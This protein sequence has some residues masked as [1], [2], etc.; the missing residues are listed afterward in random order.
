MACARRLVQGAQWLALVATLYWA[1]AAGALDRST[2]IGVPDQTAALFPSGAAAYVIE[3]QGKA[4]WSHHADRALPPASLTKMMTALLFLESGHA[5]DSPVSV[6]ARAARATGSTLRLRAGEQ[7]RARDLLAAMLLESANDACLALAEH[8]AGDKARFAAAMNRRAQA[9]GLHHTHFTN[10]CGHDER[11]HRSSARDLARLATVAMRQPVFAALAKTVEL[12]VATLDGRAFRLE[13]RNEMIGRYSG[14]IG[15]KSGFTAR[16]GK[17]L[18]VLAQRDGVTV[19]LVVLNTPNRWW[20]TAA[21]LDRAFAAAPT[22]TA[23]R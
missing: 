14:A 10:P 19:L 15:V 1:G 13:N 12:N 5:L 2:N 4:V 6:S 9:L 20:E 7:M 3:V 11:E 16:A 17:C 22:G 18:A 23:N 21:A 8:M